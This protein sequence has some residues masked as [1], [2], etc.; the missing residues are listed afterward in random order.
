MLVT[1][2][3]HLPLIDDLIATMGRSYTS[4]DAASL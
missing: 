1:F 2:N 3:L 4:R